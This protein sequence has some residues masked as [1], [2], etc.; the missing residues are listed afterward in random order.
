LDGVL[1]LSQSS[2]L[3]AREESEMS[4]YCGN[5]STILQRGSPTS[6]GTCTS[7]PNYYECRI[8]SSTNALSEISEYKDAGNCTARRLP[9]LKSRTMDMNYSKDIVIAMA[10]F[11]AYRRSLFYG[12]TSCKMETRFISYIIYKIASST[13]C[14]AHKY[15]IE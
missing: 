2:A 10:R 12:V 5:L 9:A 3:D 7:H 14:N 13:L 6:F 8:T 15:Y 11:I 4:A 1:R